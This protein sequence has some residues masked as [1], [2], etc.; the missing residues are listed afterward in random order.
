[1]PRA[2]TGEEYRQ[3]LRKALF[4]R[5]DEIEGL[6]WRIGSGIA[7]G[8]SQGHFFC[9]SVR[10]KTFLRFVPLDGVEKDI[11]TEGGT[12]LRMIECEPETPR[13]LTEEM[14]EAAYGGGQRRVRT[15]STHG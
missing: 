2:Q 4:E 7:R 15:F 12:F 11:V 3:Q 1:M 8:K 13:H 10:D 14:V 6:P 5:P 9:A